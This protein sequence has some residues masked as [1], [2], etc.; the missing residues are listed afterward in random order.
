MPDTNLR[1]TLARLAT[2]EDLRQEVRE[3][4]ERL[5]EHMTICME[6]VCRTIQALID[7]IELM[8]FIDSEARQHGTGG[9]D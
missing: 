3:E 4:G 5:R 9:A 7:A 8:K 6:R 2:A 1:S